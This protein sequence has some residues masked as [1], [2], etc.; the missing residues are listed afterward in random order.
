MLQACLNGGRD[1]DFHPAVPVTPE[2]LAHDAAAV[3]EAGADELHVHP[4][5]PDGL[6]SLHPDDTAAA[7]EAIRASVPGTRVGLSTGWWIEPGGWA[8]QEPIRAW[9]VLPDYVSVN[10]AEEDAPDVIALVLG[11][12]IG[13]EAGLWSVKDAERLATLADAPRCLRVLIEINEQDEAEG[14][15]VANGIMSTLD[16][17]KLDL[18]RLLHGTDATM[19]PIYRAALSMGLDSRI[20]LED[21]DV[22]PS[23]EQPVDNAALI[24]MARALA[25]VGRRAAASNS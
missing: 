10:L 14:L 19:W 24:R 2:E 1:R 18:P 17:A 3:V 11:M 13:V 7:L 20:G 4:R 5:N 12:G 15:A 9:T 22:L 16:R 8:R 6:E 25:E 21:G 23:G